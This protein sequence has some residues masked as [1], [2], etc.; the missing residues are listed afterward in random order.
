MSSDKLS[1]IQYILKLWLGFSLCKCTK[2]NF[3]LLSSYG[4]VPIGVAGSVSAVGL[5]RITAYEVYLRHDYCYLKTFPKKKKDFWTTNL[6]NA[7]ELAA[8]HKQVQQSSC[9]GSHLD[10]LSFTIFTIK[11]HYTNYWKCAPGLLFVWSD[12]KHSVP[13]IVFCWGQKSNF[14][15]NELQKLNILQKNSNLEWQRR[16]NEQGV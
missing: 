9:M 16:E 6:H 7:V 3:I 5:G 11:L 2:K 1:I 14:I 8:Q 10:L 13:C 15:F 12:I 4:L